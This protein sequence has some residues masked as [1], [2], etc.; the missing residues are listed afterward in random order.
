VH[1]VLAEFWQTMHT[2]ERLGAAS[3]REIATLLAQC[4]G[5]AVDQL[6]G[7]YRML[8]PYW[9]LECER[10]V[11]LAAEWLR[12]EAERGEF[13]VVACEQAASTAV[14]ALTINT[15]I[16]RID[17]M[18]D[19]GLVILDYKTGEANSSSWAV[20]RPDQPQLPLYAISAAAE[21][22]S[23]I[24]YAQ[25]KKGKCK[26]IDAPAGRARGTAPDAAQLAEWQR[27]LDDW[28]H[29]VAALSAEISSG[30]ARAAPKYGAQ[31]CRYC[32]LQSLCRIYEPSDTD[33]DTE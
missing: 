5:N 22:A 2:S 7:R 17:R 6:R 24:A 32:D 21:R 4:A 1:A 19:G 8:A 15:R 31:T 11:A 10:L 29:A 20:P 26:L 16:D 23:G 25:V 30:Y 28:G 27:Q 33:D 14:G 13:E 3:A 18:A 12:L 9:D